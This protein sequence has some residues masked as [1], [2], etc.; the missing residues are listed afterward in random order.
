VTAVLAFCHGLG[1]INGALLALG[2]WIGAGCMALMVIAILV[3]VFFRYVLNNALPW[4]EELARFL[5]LWATGLM[6]PTAYR[7]SGFVSIEVL[8][9]LL[10]RLV[11]AVLGLILGLLALVL[12]VKGAQIGWNEVSG[13]AGRAE[14]DSLRVP[15]SLAFDRWVKLPKWTMMASLVVGLVLMIA[16]NIE[17]LLRQIIALAGHDDRLKPIPDTVSLGAE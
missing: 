12:L 3:Q 1:R 14:T 5:M 15:A 16:V 6:I 13:F 8:S 7:R 2:R 4:P 10:P 17:L 9:R 11:G